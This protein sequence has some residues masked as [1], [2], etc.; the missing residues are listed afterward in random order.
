MD[1][2][3]LAQSVLNDYSKPSPVTMAMRNVNERLF[4][5]PAYMDPNLSATERAMDILNRT[6]WGLDTKGINMREFAKQ[7]AQHGTRMITGKLHTQG[8]PMEKPRMIEIV[9]MK[10]GGPVVRSMKYPNQVQ[11]QKAIERLVIG[12]DEIAIPREVS[13]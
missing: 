9:V 8:V 5:R 3:N 1:L 6:S 13:Q 4:G 12:N 10:K 11:A 7:E 2:Q